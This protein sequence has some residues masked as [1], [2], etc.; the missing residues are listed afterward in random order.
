TFLWGPDGVILS[1]NNDFEADPMVAEMSNGEFAVVWSRSGATNSI[2]MQRLDAAG[3]ALL[4][5]GG[6][7]IAGEP[8][9]IPGFAEIVAG[10]NGNAVVSWVRDINFFT[11]IKH[12]RVQAFTPAGTSA[13]P[14]PV[15]VYDAANLPI[16]YSPQLISDQAGGAV[17]CWHVSNP[18]R[19]FLFDSFVQHLDASGAELL[20]HNGVAVSSAAGMN[21]LSPRAAYNVTTGNIQVFWSEKDGAQSQSGWFAQQVDASGGLNWGA[22]GLQILPVDSSTKYLSYVEAMG[23][24]AIGVM[25]WTPGGGFGQDELIA[26]RIDAA[27]TLVWGGTRDLC[28]LPSVKSTRLSLS[29]SADEEA[30]IFWEDGRNGSDDIYAQNIDTDGDLGADFLDVDVA[31]VSLGAGGTATLDLDAGSAFAGKSY[32]MLGS[33]TG[34]SPGMG[35]GGF[36]LDL[37]P[38]PYFDLTRNQ[39]THP[40]FSAFR[41]TLDA[42]GRAIAE[43]TFPV[44]TNPA[45]VGT[46]LG[47]AFVVL[48]GGV[49]L[50]SGTVEFDLVN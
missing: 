15:E 28:T 41:G 48:D 1:S 21:H 29:V 38:G 19:G 46:T 13:W 10:V 24:G 50:A 39:P 32:M 2:S 11:S 9:A 43:V 3:S 37:N 31:S 17:L 34:S 35:G 7:P 6:I 49:V 40:L 4:T 36:H 20:P 25:T 14:G 8:G 23:D 22:A 26:A 33:N 42:Q 47:H 27:G 45:L 12:L 5:P 30:V 44:G 18:S 16:A